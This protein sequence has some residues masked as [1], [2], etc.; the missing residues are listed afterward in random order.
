MSKEKKFE[1]VHYSDYLQLDK[2]LGAQNLRSESLGKPAHD[3]MLFIIIHQVYELWFKEIQH[4]L[5]S[6]MKMFSTDNVDERNINV[7]VSRMDRIL[8]IM[9]VLIAQV[10]I[11]ET[12][13]PLDFLDFRNFLIPA[14]GFQSLQFREVE[15]LLGLKRAKR[16]TY[17]QKDYG[18]PFNQQQLGFNYSKSK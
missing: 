2:I 12:I 8:E 16:T 1:A 3:E 7:A 6:I 10:R 18:C 4:D 9:Q 17:A 11:I 5:G 13:T 15:V 14:S